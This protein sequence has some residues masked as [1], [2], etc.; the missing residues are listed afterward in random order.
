[1]WTTSNPAIEMPA[2]FERGADTISFAGGLP[3]LSGLPL[4]E[5]AAQVSRQLRLGG[6]LTLQYTTPHI[7]S[8]LVPA[9]DELMAMEGITARP[10]NLVP[11][12]GSQQGLLAVG[13]G[14]ANPGETILCQTP[15]YPGATTAFRTAGL[16]PVSAPSDGDGVHPDALRETVSRLRVDGR[17]V[18][19]L[20]VNPTFHN[21]T[22]ATMPVSRRAALLEACRDLDLLVIEDNPY[23]LLGFDGTTTPALASIDPDNVVYLGTFSKIFAPGLRCGWLATPPALTGTLRSVGEIMTLSPSAFAQ[24]ILAA[25]H[26]KH[27]WEDLISNFRAGYARRAALMT[28]ALQDVLGPEWDWRHPTGGFYVWLRHRDGT[29]TASFEQAAASAGVSFVAGR[30]FS[31]AGEHADGLRLAFS[32]TPADRIAEGIGRLAKALSTVEVAA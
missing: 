29:D 23:G 16:H 13:L 4:T 30:H 22:G 31:V 5:L 12:A 27:G 1:M 8:S 28:S 15:S 3:D 10:E 17:Q 20:Y 19:L 6:R 21:P 7:A 11:T 24:A 26:G 2:L 32:Y 18:R 25:Y 14:L 9:I